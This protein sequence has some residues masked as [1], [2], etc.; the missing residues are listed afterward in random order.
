MQNRRF[1]FIAGKADEF[2]GDPFASSMA[3][4]WAMMLP[5]RLRMFP[6]NIGELLSD[7]R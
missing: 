5:G 4:P 3:R 2:A 6:Q 7:F 1:G